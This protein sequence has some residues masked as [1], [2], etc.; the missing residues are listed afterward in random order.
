MRSQIMLNTACSHRFLVFFFP[1]VLFPFQSF[2]Y[3]GGILCGVGKDSHSKTVSATKANFPT[4]KF[5]S[6]ASNL[7]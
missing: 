3:G 4:L 6:L 1:F 7:C 5:R 2:S